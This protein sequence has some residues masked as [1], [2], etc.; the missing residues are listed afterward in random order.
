[1]F[2]SEDGSLASL[3]TRLMRGLV[4]PACPL[5]LTAER[6]LDERHQRALL[7]YY[8][9]AGAGGLAVGVHTTQF[10]IH[11]PRIGLYQP[12]LELSAQVVGETGEAGFVRVAG[13]V[14]DTAQATREARLARTLGY[15]CGLLS[16]SAFRDASVDR[17]L[18]H[19]ESVA[20]ILPLFGFY[21]QPAVGGR[22]LPYGFWRRFVEIP[23]VVAIKVAPF[24]RYQTLEVVRALSDSGRGDEIALYT[25]ND[26]H[27]VIDLLTEYRFGAGDSGSGLH[28]VGGLLGH[29]AVWTRRAS[30]L[31]EKCKQTRAGAQIPNDL[32]VLAA[33]VT[34]SNAALFDAANGFAGC[35]AGLHEILR[36]QGLM[37]GGWC[38]DPTETLS[39]GQIEEID[40]VC[41]A[42][43]HLSDDAFVAEYLDEWLS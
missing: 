37:S 31:L 28:F 32:L 5:A 20:Q 6:T 27:I 9:A 34:D 35:I 8:V 33:Q 24:S 29:W 42:Y 40:R 30:E 14:G 13:L 17:I 25:G 18:V 2:G 41:A 3:R 7:R 10:A 26:D 15:E 11:D 19:C 39:S 4:I 43:P 23:Q 16:L 12:L 1:M 22:I 21:L 38:L 36:R